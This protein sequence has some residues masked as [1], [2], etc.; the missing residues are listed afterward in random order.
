MKPHI[1]KAIVLGLLPVVSVLH[2]AE[3][4]HKVTGEQAVVAG[5]NQ[6]ALK[7][8]LHTMDDLQNLQ[9]PDFKKFRVFAVDAM[10]VCQKDDPEL[11]LRLT[12]KICN[13]LTSWNF[14]PAD[15][16]EASSLAYTFASRMLDKGV[17]IPPAIRSTLTISLLPKQL[18]D[19]RSGSGE[20][21][22]QKRKEASIRWVDAVHSVE[23]DIDPAFDVN[24]PQ[25]RPF[26]TVPL[27]P[28]AGVGLPGVAPS[29]IKNP[30][31]RKQYKDAIAQNAQKAQR[32][33]HQ[34][35]L[36]LIKSYLQGPATSY[37]VTAYSKEPH[38]ADELNTLLNQIKDDDFKRNVL[39]LVEQ[40]LEKEKQ[41]Q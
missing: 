17:N 4:Q 16:S 35:Q 27:P 21:L 31:V 20:E 18:D 36:R 3:V 39:T 1:S 33:N 34:T 30:V 14:P 2:S 28:G 26:L 41:T 6:Q 10:K 19:L 11:S 29:A 7:E 25:N 38:N 22:S 8:A 40:N 24:D 32:L 5:N 12:A 23:S 13:A 9:E 15:R 37:L